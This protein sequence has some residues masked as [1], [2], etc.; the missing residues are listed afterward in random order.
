MQLA[1]FTKIL[2]ISVDASSVGMF[3]DE[4]RRRM[5]SVNPA[6]IPRNW[7]LQEAIVDAEKD[8]FEKV[9]ICSICYSYEYSQT[10]F[11]MK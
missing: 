1:Y 6:Y 8:D 3:E 10:I 11:L 4:R 9:C 2:A 7:L 5:L